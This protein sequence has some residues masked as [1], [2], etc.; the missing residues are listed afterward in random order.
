M[1]KGR[2]AATLNP[3][4]T[5]YARGIA[6]QMVNGEAEFFAPSCPVTSDIGQYKRF[7]DKDAFAVEETER[8]IG[9]PAKRIEMSADDATYNCKPNALELPID[10]A[11][12]DRAGDN[13]LG[14]QQAKTRVLLSTAQRSHLDKVMTVIN[15]VSAVSGV[16]EWSSASNDP[17]AEINAQ[18]EDI[19]KNTGMMPTSLGMSLSAW[20]TISEHAKVLERIKTGIAKVD[21]K[22]VAN[23]FMVPLELKVCAAVKD[24]K[25]KGAAKSNQFIM[26]SNVFLFIKSPNPTIYDPGFAKTFRGGQDSVESVRTY[27]EE[28][29]RSDILAV[30]WSVDVQVVG[31]ETCRR[32]VLS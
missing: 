25:K 4:L 10:D 15:T 18:I 3:T 1:A 22:D 2:E 11:E 20:R 23:L 31:T 16:G 29:N 7:D 19:A 6:P 13:V 30:D 26:G 9:G 17:I 27:R 5:N 21:V 12:I 8:A 24:T 14:L 28:S 32:I